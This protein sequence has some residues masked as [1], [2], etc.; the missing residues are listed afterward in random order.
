MVRDGNTIDA[1][2]LAGGD[3]LIERG[4][5]VHRV[6]GVDVKI[7]FKQGESFLICGQM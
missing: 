1:F 7:G 4:A 2:L 3:N 6:K 5:A